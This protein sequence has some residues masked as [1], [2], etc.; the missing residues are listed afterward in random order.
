MPYSTDTLYALVT[1]LY[2]I[3]FS[4]FI[5]NVCVIN[6]TGGHNAPRDGILGH[7]WGPLTTPHFQDMGSLLAAFDK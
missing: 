5:Y 7:L 6:I 4:K 1:I 3:T 2:R